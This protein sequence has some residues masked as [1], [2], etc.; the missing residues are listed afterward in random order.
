MRRSKERKGVHSSPNKSVKPIKSNW[1]N[2]VTVSTT[3]TIQ[4]AQ[5]KT[6]QNEKSITQDKEG[7]SKSKS[8]VAPVVINSTESVS[9]KDQKE[10]NEIY[11]EAGLNPKL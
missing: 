4:L 3:G 7:V 2:K 5:N 10:S 9:V 8:A 11:S 1:D 6:I